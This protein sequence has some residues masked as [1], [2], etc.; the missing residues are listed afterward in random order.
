MDAVFYYRNGCH[1][2]EAM[3]AVLFRGWPEQAGAMAWRDVDQ[4]PAW[5]DS[6]GDRV[7]VLVIGD[8]EIC[9]FEAD[10]ARITQ[11]F[12]EISNPL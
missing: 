5:R 12:G 4:Q 9:S 10:I 7:P 8:T 3:A 2:C 11:Y 1:L 6:Y